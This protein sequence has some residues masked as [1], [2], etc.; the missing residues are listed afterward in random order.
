V[1]MSGDGFAQ[2]MRTYLEREDPPFFA[3]FGIRAEQ[4]DVDSLARLV[5]DAVRI[6]SGDLVGIM[7]DRVFAY[8]DSARPKDL[9]A[10][11]IRLQEQALRSGLGELEIESMGFPANEDEVRSLVYRPTWS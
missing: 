4:G 5:L 11:R 1:P 7:D 10:L 8:L 2:S 6:E 9:G 3:L